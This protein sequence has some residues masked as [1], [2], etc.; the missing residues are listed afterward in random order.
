MKKI[1]K[2]FYPRLHCKLTG[3]NIKWR[4]LINQ[5][6]SDQKRH[7]RQLP[8]LQVVVVVRDLVIHPGF[9]L[10]FLEVCKRVVSFEIIGLATRSQTH[11]VALPG[12]VV[13][14]DQLYDSK[15]IQGSAIDLVSRDA[16][17]GTR[18]KSKQ[19]TQGWTKH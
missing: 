8:R 12:Y 4:M 9:V 2:N 5:G 10:P 1:Q 11:A 3:A 17:T 6:F 7:L 19:I 16:P 15:P 18:P 13:M 14:I